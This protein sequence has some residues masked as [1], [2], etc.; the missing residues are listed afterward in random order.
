[1]S[2]ISISL[3]VLDQPSPWFYLEAWLPLRNCEMDY[4]CAGLD[5]KIH[6]QPGSFA[7]VY[8]CFETVLLY[9]IKLVDSPG[10]HYYFMISLMATF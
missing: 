10:N 8:F 6:N 7:A 4:Y 1:M 5:L 2:I 9:L 3:T